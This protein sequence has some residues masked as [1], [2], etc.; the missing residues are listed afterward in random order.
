[1]STADAAPA[2]VQIQP[3]LNGPGASTNVPHAAA[4]TRSAQTGRESSSLGTF[5][6]GASCHHPICL[7]VLLII[8]GQV[9]SCTDAKSPYVLFNRVD[10]H[11]NNCCREGLL[12]M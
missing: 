2:Q 4:P 3:V 7:S 6:V 9:W 8:T 10:V 11:A 1:M 5:G 12:W